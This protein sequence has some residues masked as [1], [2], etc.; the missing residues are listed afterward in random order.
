MI[1]I[2]LFLAFLGL[3][4]YIDWRLLRKLRSA[5]FSLDIIAYG[6]LILTWVLVGVLLA[7]VWFMM[8][9]LGTILL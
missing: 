1:D 6:I 3:W 4:I 9:L 7:A 5:K 2:L 8:I